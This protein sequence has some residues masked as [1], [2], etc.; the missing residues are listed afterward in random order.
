MYFLYGES[1]IY[2]F[3]HIVVVDAFLLPFATQH[4]FVSFILYIFGMLSLHPIRTRL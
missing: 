1:V 4:R 2:Y 3:K